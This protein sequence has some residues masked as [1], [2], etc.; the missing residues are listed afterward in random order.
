[1]VSISYKTNSVT[2]QLSGS[3]PFAFRCCHH[4]LQ[5]TEVISKLSFRKASFT[6]NLSSHAFTW[7]LG[8]MS[9]SCISM[10]FIRKKITCHRSLAPTN[11]DHDLGDWGGWVGGRGSS[12][13]QLVKGQGEV[14]VCKLTAQTQQA[15]TW[16]ICCMLVHT[17]LQTNFCTL[18]QH[19]T[20]LMPQ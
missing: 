15:R 14:V 1:M 20:L 13:C 19:C 12:T 9:R 17:G 3:Q 10:T 11:T 4:T 7:V 8:T 6:A 5:R 16:N 18:L 2:P